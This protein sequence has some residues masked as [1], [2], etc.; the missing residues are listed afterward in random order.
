M[1]PDDE[2]DVIEENPQPPEEELDQE[3]SAQ[4]Q[5]QGDPSASSGQDLDAMVR[6]AVRE[7]LTDFLNQ[8]LSEYEQKRFGPAIQSLAQQVVDREEKLMA[9]T[10]QRIQQALQAASQ[11]PGPSTN[12]HNHQAEE[13]LDAQQF[14][15]QTTANIEAAKKQ[16]GNESSTGAKIL[17]T[18][19]AVLPLLD[20]GFDR[21][22]QYQQVMF[23][24][25]DPFQIF[26][27]WQ[28]EQPELTRFLA[29]SVAPRDPLEPQLP[30]LLA[31]NASDVWQMAYRAGIQAGRQGKGDPVPPGGD[32]D[33]NPLGDW[34]GGSGGPGASSA[35]P[36]TGS[37]VTLENRPSS[38]PYGNS[39]G[40]PDRS[41]TTPEGWPAATPRMTKF[42]DLVRR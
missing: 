30:H 12:G 5:P 39:Y 13:E 9:Q 24:L 10:D 28:N 31:R 6:Q 20:H 27:Q 23:S 32:Y 21:F 41:A 15:E 8:V 2:Q 18:V 3:P 26:R 4:D 35:G 29:M 38:T 14:Y 40:R 42:S 22:M 7:E 1:I 17:T 25:K 33:P 19:Q 36:T 37:A 16:L 34:T 11:G